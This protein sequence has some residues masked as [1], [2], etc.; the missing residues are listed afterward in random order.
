MN[1]S[2]HSVPSSKL[3]QVLH[4]YQLFAMNALGGP[5]HWN[6]EMAKLAA[7]A[8]ARY[9]EAY[10]AALE[11]LH[12]GKDIPRSL[13]FDFKLPARLSIPQKPILIQADSQCEQGE[14]L[15]EGE[16]V[17]CFDI[18]GE[19][20]LCLPQLLKTVLSKYSLDVINQACD[21]LYIYCSRCN[22]EQLEMFKR[23]GNL[24][25]TASTCGLITMTDAER[26]CAALLHS[27]TEIDHNNRGSVDSERRRINESCIPVYHECFG[28]GH[29][30]LK[31]DLYCSQDA[32]CIECVDCSQLFSPKRFVGHSHNN[33][34]TRT[35]H[36][37]FDR[38]NWRNYIMCESDKIHDVAERSRL[39]AA[40]E[41]LIGRFTSPQVSP[42]TRKRKV[43]L[44]SIRFYVILKSFDGYVFIHYRYQ[45][46][47]G[48]AY[49]WQAK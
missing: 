20:R 9:T 14:T 37:G 23:S 12:S 28:E 43:R 47:Q 31:S 8:G 5:A 44:N 15:L 7:T 42:S 4:N 35:C 33:S 24:P 46:S 22:P 34:E 38:N 29:G 21:D 25:Y 32:K 49:C 26:L 2:A 36:W 18:G 16:S 39:E 27:S 11:S 10:K 1:V 48:Q 45:M 13:P 30:Y 19:K 41:N 6:A 3:N 17:A 40:F